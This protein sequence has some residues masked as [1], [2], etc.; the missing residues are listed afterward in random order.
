M[1]NYWKFARVTPVYKGKGPRTDKGKYRPISVL[2]YVFNI[3][4]KKIQ[5]QILKYFVE[6][7]FISIDQFAFQKHHSRL[8]CRHHV[9]DDC[10]LD[11]QNSFDTV[12][13][14]LFLE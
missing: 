4:E 10:F 11:N 13:Q 6:H 5:A 3:M 1:A 14:E 9:V 12:N 8:T 2:S 7:D